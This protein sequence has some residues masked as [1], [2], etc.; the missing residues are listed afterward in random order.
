ML[1]KK[2]LERLAG[3]STEYYATAEN[4][5]CDLEAWQYAWLR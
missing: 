5:S 1:R 3:R 2:V 4:L